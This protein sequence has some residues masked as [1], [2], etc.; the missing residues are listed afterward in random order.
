VPQTPQTYSAFIGH[1]LL[2]SGPL[3]EVAIPV[4]RALEDLASHHVLVFDNLTGRQLDFDLT[5]SESEVRA[6]FSVATPASGPEVPAEPRRRGRPRL[7]VVA[8]EVTLLP[9]HWE[10]LA[11]QSGGASVALR[12]LVEH[13]RRANGGNQELRQR[14]E[15]AYQFMSSIGGNLAG[16]EEASRA[17]FANDEAAFRE[18]MKRWPADVRELTLRLAYDGGTTYLSNK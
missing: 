16:F 17:L 18:R 5:G 13:A 9:R 15:R 12:K 1:D 10:W 3:A 14:Q 7:G 8:R 4:K 11:T 2:V 6:R